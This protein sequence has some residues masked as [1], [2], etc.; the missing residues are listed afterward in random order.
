MIFLGFIWGTKTPNNLNFYPNVKSL[1][2]NDMFKID[3]KMFKIYNE[4]YV[5]NNK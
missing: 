3:K 5:Y 1:I 2:I 4:K